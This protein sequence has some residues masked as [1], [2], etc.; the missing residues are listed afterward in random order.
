MPAR[1]TEMPERGKSTAPDT[2]LLAILIAT[3]LIYLRCLSNEFVFDDYYMIL[4]NRYIGDWSFFWKSL[5][6]DAYW[7]TDPLHVPVSSYYRPIKDV[8]FAINI[9]LFG[10]HPAGW[11]AAMIALHLFVVWLVYRVA[12]ELTRDHFAALFAA[13]IFALMPSHAE[14]VVYPAAIAQPLCAAFESAAFL[15]FLRQNDEDVSGRHRLAFSLLLYAGALLSYE[16]AITFPALIAAYVYIFR[17]S[18]SNERMNHGALAAAMPY[19]LMVIPY[20][21]IRYWVLGFITRPNPQNPVPMTGIEAFL[22]IPGAIAAYL[23]LLVVPWRAGPAYRLDVVTSITSPGFYLS[24]AVLAVICAAAI[25]L[26]RRNPRRNLYLFCVAWFFIAIAPALNLSGLFSEILIQDRYLYLASIAFCVMAADIAIDIARRGERWSQAVWAVGLCGVAAF[27]SA[28]F[29]V[30][31]YWHDDATLFAQCAEVSPASEFWHYRLGVTMMAQGQNAKAL[32]ELESAVR[33]APNYVAARYQLAQVYDALGDRAGFAR[34]TAD[35]VKSFKHPPLEAY[36][37]LATAD[38][39]AGDAKG[40]D[41]ALKNAEVLPGGI[42]AAALTRAQLMLRHGDSKRADAAL[43]PMLKRE[44]DDPAVLATYGLVLA[45]EHRYDEAIATMRRAAELS[46][47]APMTH[48]RIA[49]LL[50]QLGRDREARDECAIT[51]AA[52]PAARSAQELMAD[53]ERSEGVR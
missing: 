42:D 41:D 30:Q 11:H 17:L 26:F 27:A 20:L 19:A 52:A 32:P 13:G 48:Y 28:L 6:N 24:V 36:T 29:V 23:K 49:I 35:W 9:H 51:L 16:G 1:P 5:V 22:T 21:V 7:S 25:W 50:H 8:W 15:V 34:A 43:Q 45:A 33:L 37:A 47:P 18:S 4:A 40:A 3:A 2:W 31:G 12:A 39:A 53:I 14:T 10:R 38:D 46:P 44:P